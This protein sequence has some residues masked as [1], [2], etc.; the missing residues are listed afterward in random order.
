MSD[1]SP[2]VSLDR[3][4]VKESAYLKSL[5]EFNSDQ[6]DKGL[7]TKLFVE[8]NGDEKRVKIAYLEIRAREIFSEPQVV[9]AKTTDESSIRKDDAVTE[10]NIVST[11]DRLIK[12]QRLNFCAR[13]MVFWVFLLFGCLFFSVNFPE[14]FEGAEGHHPLFGLIFGLSFLV[15]FVISINSIWYLANEAGKFGGLWAISSFIFF[16]LG[17]VISYFRIKKIATERGWLAR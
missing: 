12:Y 13:L 4:K 2:K 16:P 14:I 15:P 10:V 3:D 1:E 11:N 6:Q 9:L 7:Y 8:L 17:F 5:E